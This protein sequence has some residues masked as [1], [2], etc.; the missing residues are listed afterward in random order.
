MSATGAFRARVGGIPVKTRVRFQ[1]SMLAR[2][3]PNAGGSTEITTRTPPFVPLHG[4]GR[5]TPDPQALKR[6]PQD[7]SSD[8]CT[9]AAPYLQGTTNGRMCLLLFTR[10][11]MRL[12][13]VH[14]FL[15]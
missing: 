2:R 10:Q 9:G 1:Q 5:L 3:Q 13:R 11:Q 8:S 7:S 15:R 14:Q 12:L 6:P 4:V